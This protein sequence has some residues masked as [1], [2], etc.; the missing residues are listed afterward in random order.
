ML[1]LRFSTAAQ[2]SRSRLSLFSITTKAA[3]DDAH[4]IGFRR[5]CFKNAAQQEAALLHD[6]L[7]LLALFDGEAEILSARKRAAERPSDGREGRQRRAPARQCLSHAITRSR[8]QMLIFATGQHTRHTI[9]CRRAPADDA[10]ERRS[11]RGVT[12]SISRH[13]AVADGHGKLWRH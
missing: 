10:G 1:I 7:L 9:D 5:A 13:Y 8:R 12:F 3:I 6:T 4:E 2:N 11:G